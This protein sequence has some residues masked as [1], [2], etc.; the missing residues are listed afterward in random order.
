MAALLQRNGH[1]IMQ[2]SNGEEALIKMQST[3]FDL[4]I[5]D[6]RMSPIDGINLL[7][8]AKKMMP[9]AEVIFI[10]G[11]GSLKQGVEA[12]KMGA[13]DFLEKPASNERL[14]LLIDHIEEKKRL[15]KELSSL[16]GELRGKHDFE[17]IIGK[18][19]TMMNVLKL[20]SQVS[21]T[22]TTVLI[23]GESGTGKELVARAIHTNSKRRNFHMVA[24]NCGALPES[25]QESELFG[26]VKGSFTGAIRDKKGLFAEAH[27]GTLFLDEIGAMSLS[28]QVKLL[29]FL[30]DGE[31]R[32]VGD[33]LPIQADVRLIAAT[34][35]DLEKEID[36]N[37]FREDLFYRL[38]VIPIILPPLRER[39]DDIPLLINH[40]LKKY[41]KKLGVEIKTLSDKAMRILQNYD[42]PGNVRELENAIERAIVLTHN[43]EIQPSALPDRITHRHKTPFS[44]GVYLGLT[45]SEV[46]RRHIISTLQNCDN[47]LKKAYVSLGIKES[48][49]VSKIEEHDIKIEPE[50]EMSG[51]SSDVILESG[52]FYT[53]AE[54][55]NRRSK[56]QGSSTILVDFG[57][58]LP[59]LEEKYILTMLD[60]VNGIRT[61]AAKQLGISQVT[62]WRKL[63]EFDRQAHNGRDSKSKTV[64]K[65][66]ND[67]VLVNL[68]NEGE[69]SD[70]GLSAYLE[71][72]IKQGLTLNDVEKQYIMDTLHVSNGKKKET[73]FRLG[74]SKATLW[75]KLKAFKLQ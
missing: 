74:I 45:L 12:M 33:N 69:L 61:K 24:V 35:K 43:K 52:Y 36:N 47:D 2:C 38:S 9:T 5:T 40:F 23:S 26:H 42:W 46:N 60:K 64:P 37:A 21:Q 54:I 13:F 32:K 15:E 63:K 11:V 19:K 50:S 58:T 62:L 72:A 16:R 27:N 55:T 44:N 59:Q 71:D 70:N 20:V 7:H 30:Q 48:D 14:L 18:S 39:R 25:L 6:L 28:A 10:T 53:T 4:I 65:H 29:R 56:K 51:S 41:S 22:D 57:L 34:N 3:I 68:P 49:L 1:T 73:A 75:R 17:A 66:M 31:I 67:F 8:E